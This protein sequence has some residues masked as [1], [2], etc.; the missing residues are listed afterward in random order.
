MK[1][2]QAKWTKKKE[3]KK[4]RFD[5]KW[6]LGFKTTSSSLSFPILV[7]FLLSTNPNMLP[8]LLQRFSPQL[9]KSYYAANK[10]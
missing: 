2:Q 1:S 6:D 9:I 7:L 3:K 5:H 4:T 8:V 10:R